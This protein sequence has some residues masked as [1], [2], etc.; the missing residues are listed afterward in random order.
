MVNGGTSDLLRYSISKT[1]ISISPVS[2]FGLF[3][4]LSETSPS[5]LMTNSLPHFL[6]R[7]NVL[8]PENSSSNI[9]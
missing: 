7:L 5:I 4:N 3:D 9:S 2:I 6:A 8:L 1:L